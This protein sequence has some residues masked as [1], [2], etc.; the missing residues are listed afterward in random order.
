MLQP[1]RIFKWNCALISKG[2]RKDICNTYVT[3]G[4]IKGER[5]AQRDRKTCFLILLYQ[6]LQTRDVKMRLNSNCFYGEAVLLFLIYRTCCF[7]LPLAYFLK[8]LSEHHNTFDFVPPFP[9]L[10]SIKRGALKISLCIY[11]RTRLMTKV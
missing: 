2:K 8:D 3:F 7:F 9:K 4:A 10:E 1:S 11:V 6:W 5:W